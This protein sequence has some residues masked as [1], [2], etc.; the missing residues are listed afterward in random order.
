MPTCLVSFKMLKYQ[1]IKSLPRGECMS[2]VNDL[3]LI[4]HVPLRQEMQ[5][6]NFFL[7]GLYLSS[8]ES[9]HFPAKCSKLH[10]FVRYT[11][12]LAENALWCTKAE[13]DERQPIIY[14]REQKLLSCKWCFQKAKKKNERKMFRLKLPHTLW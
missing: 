12:Y 11:T 8:V 2:V 6:H 10:T 14:S 5:R 1:K 3:A 9:I 4:R 13:Q 7:D